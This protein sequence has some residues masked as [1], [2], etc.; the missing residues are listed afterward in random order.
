[1]E[2]VATESQP[3]TVSQV[4]S[5]SARWGWF[6]VW[7]LVLALLIALAV[8]LHRNQ[9]DFVTSG[10][11]APDF[12]LTTFEGDQ[13]HMADLS[14]KIVVINFWASWCKPC[15]QE[16]ADLQRGWEHYESRDEVIF[17]GVGYVDTEPE[18]LAYLE[19]FEI[20]YPNGPDLGTRISQAFRIVGVPETYFIDRNSNLAHVQVGPFVSLGEITAI[21]DNLLGQQ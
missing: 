18:A 20:T 10:E 4:S 13:I 2:S 8:R 14:G 11:Q 16:A 17:L 5:H 9:Q 3:E 21:V 19:R 1:M 6:V 15:E 12:T 7:G